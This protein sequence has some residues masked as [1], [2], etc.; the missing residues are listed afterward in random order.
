MASWFDKLFNRVQDA[1]KSGDEN[2]LSRIKDE[3]RDKIPPAAMKDESGTRDEDGIHI[4]M[5]GS[6]SGGSGAGTPPLK[7]EYDPGEEEMDGDLDERV[8]NL[9]G[10]V[11]KL[12]AMVEGD[13]GEVELEDPYTRDAKRFVMRRGTKMKAKDED[14]VPE[15]QDE[16]IAET[17]LP[18]IEDL[19]AREKSRN[20]S[21]DRRRAQ[22]S[23][24]QEHLWQDTIALG[25]IIAPSIRIPTF[26]AR[27]PALRTAE[28]LCA[29]RRHVMT[30]AFDD[31]GTRELIKRTG[32][33]TKDALAKCP[34]DVVKIAFTSVGNWVKEKNNALVTRDKV[35]SGSVP[36]A[37]DKPALT[38][39]EINK[40]HREYYAKQV[41]TRH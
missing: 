10:Q 3:L 21:Q 24:N 7:D 27:L 15:R 35:P 32:V 1:A 41:N 20:S 36:N 14:N 33:S 17:D 38:N 8:A 40:L 22:D 39:A 31:E 11:A 34:C 6:G 13:E 28:R 29:F 4:H 26:D 30:N 23:A 5:H 9:E 37:G 19:D 25:A 2:E 16:M 18:G 12:M